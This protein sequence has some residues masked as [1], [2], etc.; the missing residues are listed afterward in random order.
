M[1]KEIEIARLLNVRV[2]TETGKVYVEME[3]TDPTWKQKI[4][5]NWKNLEVR[6]VVEEKEVLDETLK[7]DLVAI[8]KQVEKWR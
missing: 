8:N 6:L 7:E 1:S 5:R 3:V 2:D 4:L